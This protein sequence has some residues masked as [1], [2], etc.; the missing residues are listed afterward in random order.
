MKN[1]GF[2]SRLAWF[3]GIWLVSV[4]LLAFLAIAIRAAIL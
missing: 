2:I 4:A 1:E 3:I